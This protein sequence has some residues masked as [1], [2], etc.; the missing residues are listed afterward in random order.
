MGSD[1]ETAEGT[2]G[3]HRA[4]G[5]EGCKW[6]FVIVGTWRASY[7]LPLKALIK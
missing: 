3:I 2:G 1:C 7:R 4:R 6:F 5:G